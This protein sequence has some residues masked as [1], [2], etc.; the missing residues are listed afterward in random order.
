MIYISFPPRVSSGMSLD[1][2]ILV[3]DLR[4]PVYL[5]RFRSESV[6]GAVF[7]QCLVICIG[8]LIIAHLQPRPGPYQSTC[9]KIIV[10]REQH[11][12]LAHQLRGVV[13]VMKPLLGIELVSLETFFL[14]FLRD[15]YSVE[16]LLRILGYSDPGRP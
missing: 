2:I 1:R 15:G 6:I 5:P 9:G 13:P 3:R 11:R 16:Y 8:S 14:L 4:E 10:P 7:Q 12:R